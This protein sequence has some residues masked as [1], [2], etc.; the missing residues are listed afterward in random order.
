MFLAFTGFLPNHW[1]IIV[2]GEADWENREKTSWLLNGCEVLAIVVKRLRWLLKSFFEGW[3]Y[4]IKELWKNEAK[5]TP[6]PNLK[7]S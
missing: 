7:M 2:H 4:G 3:G 1:S 6:H 5:E